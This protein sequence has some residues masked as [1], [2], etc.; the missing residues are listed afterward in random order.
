MP[1]AGNIAGCPVRIAA[2]VGRPHSSSNSSLPRVAGASGICPV[3]RARRRHGGQVT[4]DFLI[5][6]GE[7]ERAGKAWVEGRHGDLGDQRVG[8]TDVDLT[9]ARRTSWSLVARP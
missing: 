9:V 6:E 8:G 3:D 1:H 7:V 2:D 5:A 4:D